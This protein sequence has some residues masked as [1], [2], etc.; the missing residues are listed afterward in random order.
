VTT[1][2]TATPVAPPA[3][4]G[5]IGPAEV[6]QR[7]KFLMGSSTKPSN[8]GALPS[9]TARM[10]ATEAM[11]AR[12]ASYTAPPW[13]DGEPVMYRPHKAKEERI[14]WIA[15]SYNK[16]FVLWAV[17]PGKGVEQV[18]DVAYYDPAHVATSDPYAAYNINGSFRKT[19]FPELVY[20]ILS[21]RVDVSFEGLSQTVARLEERVTKVA[22]PQT[23]ERL[24][25][26]VKGT[27]TRAAEMFQKLGEMENIFKTSGIA[28]NT[29]RFDE[30]ERKVHALIEQIAAMA[31][32]E[33][34]TE[35]VPAATG[36]AKPN[37]GK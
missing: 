8:S 16:T 33:E 23:I 30:L 25:A 17:S 1:A 4:N 32:E 15:T 34:D 22:T 20:A 13:V 6:G 12:R 36:R 18:R 9:I 27:E 10:T 19:R 26:K 29:A 24:E 31:E 5:S 11:Q 3:A 14:A 35:E 37:G 2:A 7:M 21:G 28:Q